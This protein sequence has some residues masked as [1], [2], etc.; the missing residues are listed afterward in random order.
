MKRLRLVVF[1][2]LVVAST[3]LGNRPVSA[4]EAR[5]LGAVETTDTKDQFAEAYKAAD[6]AVERKRIPNHIFA[7][8]A[9]VGTPSGI[10]LNASFYWWRL[11]F[12]GAGMY[13]NPDFYGVQA[14]IGFSFLHGSR[15]R[16]SISFVMGNMR[17]KPMLVLDA[18][19][20]DSRTGVVQ[21]DTYMGIS[22]DIFVD[23]VF[24]QGGIASALN[25]GFA[26]PVLL[27]QAGYL[28]SIF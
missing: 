9:T 15:F 23:G 13:Y 20:P 17:R 10:D 1:F 27:F 12:R 7:V 22:Y 19:F 16:H 4:I 8:G 18:N 24:F 5:S 3:A 28:F 25:G 2:L 26:N 6:E 14:D 21:Q 11:V